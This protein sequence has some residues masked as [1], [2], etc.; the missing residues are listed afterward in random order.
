MEQV[1]DNIVKKIVMQDKC[2]GADKRFTPQ[3]MELYVI[4]N[5]KQESRMNVPAFNVW[6]DP[7]PT[8]R[9]NSL[10]DDI[11]SD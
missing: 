10:R 1:S 4:D 6:V 8:S 11:Y 9:F 5:D 2:P 7:G 3:Q